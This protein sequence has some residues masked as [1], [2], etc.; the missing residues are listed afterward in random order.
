[1]EKAI[2]NNSLDLIHQIKNLSNGNTLHEIANSSAIDMCVGIGCYPE[3]H[4]FSNDFDKKLI[5]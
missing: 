5:Y 3:K 2:N 1:M 4:A